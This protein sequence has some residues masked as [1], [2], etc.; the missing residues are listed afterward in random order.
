MGDPAQL[1]ATVISQTAG[2]KG[3]SQSMFKRLMVRGEG[4][5]ARGEG[6]GGTWAKRALLPR[7]FGTLVHPGG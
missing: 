6:G 2:D 3:Y 1:P 4:A 7:P 5:R